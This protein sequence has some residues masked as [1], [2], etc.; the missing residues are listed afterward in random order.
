M[1]DNKNNSQEQNKIDALND[2]LTSASEK[3]AGNRKIIYWCV[4]GIVLVAVFIMSY[5]FFYRNPRTND[6]YAAYG[7]VGLEAANDTVAAKEYAKVAEQ[8]GSAGGGNLA[9]LSA[10]QSY[11]NIGKYKEALESLKKFSTSDDVLMSNVEILIGDCYVNLKNY[12][13]ALQ[14][15]DKG[16]KTA[17]TNEQIVPRAQLKKAVVFDHL[18]KYDEAL[19]CYEA[20]KAQYPNFVPGNGMSIDGYIAREKARLGK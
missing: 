9:A 10:G 14:A 12:P 1:A 16:I 17:G 15:F 5:L 20:V 13:E 8:F 18:K 2:Q 4:G 7:K 3:L 11:Y 19:A 6:S